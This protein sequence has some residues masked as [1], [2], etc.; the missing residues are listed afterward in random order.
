MKTCREGNASVWNRGLWRRLG[1]TGHKYKST[2]ITTGIGIY[3]FSAYQVS[4][5]CFYDWGTSYL[6]NF[7]MR[8]TDLQIQRLKVPCISLPASLYQ[9]CERVAQLC[10]SDAPDPSARSGWQDWQQWWCSERA[11]GPPGPM[12]L[13][14]EAAG[15]VYGRAL[16]ALIVWAVLLLS[17]SKYWSC[18]YGL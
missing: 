2:F 4:Q 15:S 13:V 5:P 9:E 3:R 10:Q 12:M 11:S 6:M 8:R 14:V 7:G 16:T 1:I 17:Y 18:L